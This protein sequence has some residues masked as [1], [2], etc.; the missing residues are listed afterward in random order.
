MKEGM[1]EKMAH[2]NLVQEV[3]LKAVSSLLFFGND[4]INNQ[5]SHLM[6][7]KE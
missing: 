7:S 2:L 1:K 5:A 6:Q 4:A 3:S